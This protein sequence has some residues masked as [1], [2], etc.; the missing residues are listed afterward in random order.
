M[1]PIELL[2]TLFIIFIIL[3]IANGI[4]RT[5]SNTRTIS[6]QNKRIIEL[7]ETISKKNQ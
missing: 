4:A 7:L 2:I 6:E 5:S 1:P 3:Y